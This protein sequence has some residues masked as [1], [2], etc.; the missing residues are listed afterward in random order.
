[1]SDER[2]S[3]S[4]L[5]SLLSFP[6][7]FREGCGVQVLNVI[8]MLEM[9]PLTGIMKGELKTSKAPKRDYHLNSKGGFKF[10]PL[11]GIAILYRDN[12]ARL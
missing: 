8:R 2:G 9:K 3:I 7:T 1:M 12:E 10:A 6:W 11:G 4:L 5:S